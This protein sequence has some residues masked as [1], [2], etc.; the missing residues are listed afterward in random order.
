MSQEEIKKWLQDMATS[1]EENIEEKITFRIGE[2]E[3]EYHKG[4]GEFTTIKGALFLTTHNSHLFTV[5]DDKQ[6]I[7]DCFCIFGSNDIINIDE[8]YFQYIAPFDNKIL[9]ISI[10]QIKKDISTLNDEFL[11][12][13]GIWEWEDG[14]FSCVSVSERELA[15]VKGIA[16]RY[17]F[18][19]EYEPSNFEQDVT[20]EDIS[21]I[22]FDIDDFEQDIINEINY[23]TV[24]SV[25]SDFK[26]ELVMMLTQLKNELEWLPPRFREEF[27]VNFICQ[28][29][30]DSHSVRKNCEYFADTIVDELTEEEKSSMYITIG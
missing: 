4:D 7:T 24:D 22:A 6:G 28:C 15:L 21:Q 3:C 25:A 5:R 13:S 11:K 18:K 2:C 20:L 9:K 29:P 26:D 10:N 16:K 23:M 14:G 8:E 17:P 19:Y 1:L 30:Q 27:I 12:C